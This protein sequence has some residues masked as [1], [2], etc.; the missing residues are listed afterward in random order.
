MATAI[1]SGRV[2]EDVK[3]RVARLIQAAGLSAGDVIKTVWDTIARTGEVPLPPV[4]G[5]EAEARRRRFAAF[6]ELRAT[7]PP[8]PALVEMDDAALRAQVAERYEEGLGGAPATASGS[9]APAA[10]TCGKG[11]A[12]HGA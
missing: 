1:V 8:C 7:L 6:M 4:E 11:G 10:C 9:M 2:D 3:D 12:N 5:S